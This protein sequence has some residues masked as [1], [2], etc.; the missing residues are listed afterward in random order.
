MRELSLCQLGQRLISYGHIDSGL[1]ARCS[2]R[3]GERLRHARPS[4]ENR[5]RGAPSKLSS[6]LSQRASGLRRSQRDGLRGKPRAAHTI[7][8]ALRSRSGGPGERKG[9]SMPPLV[10]P[11]EREPSC[12]RAGRREKRFLIVSEFSNAHSCRRRPPRVG[13]LDGT[14]RAPTPMQQRHPHANRQLLEL[15]V[16]RQARL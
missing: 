7:S 5:A 16:G 11:C 15:R 4:A 13:T 9:G 3:S 2:A 6:V 8:G 12:D 1:A 14:A 10:G